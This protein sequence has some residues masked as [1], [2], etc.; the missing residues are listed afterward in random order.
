MSTDTT[1]PYPE[2]GLDSTLI[3]SL[4]HGPHIGETLKRPK[5]TESSAG[6]VFEFK[7][8]TH[9]AND[10][11]CIDQSPSKAISIHSIPD[12]VLLEIFDLCSDS[13]N[14]TRPIF[15]KNEGDPLDR[16]LFHVCKR[17]RYLI[18]AS[19]S[20]LDL[21]LFCSSG[22]PVR[23]GLG[24]LPAFPIIIDYDEVTSEDEDNVVAAL[25][26][27]DRVRRITLSGITRTLWEKLDAAMRKP[28]PALTHVYLTGPTNQ[29]ERAPVL[30][31]GL[32]GGGTL[33]LKEL[34]LHGMSYPN[35]PKFLLSAR[36]LVE[37]RFANIPPTCFVLPEDMLTGLAGL[38]RLES[39][40]IGFR[41]SIR[42]NLLTDQKLT[43]PTTPAVRLPVLDSFI[44]KGYCE[45]LED[46]LSQI[47]APRV[48]KFNIDYFSQPTYQVPQLARFLARSEIFRPPGLLSV[49]M[50]YIPWTDIWFCGPN[51]NLIFK[52]SS[53]GMVRGILHS[54]QLCQQL[55]TLFSSIV[56]LYLY[57]PAPASDQS[58]Y[59]GSLYGGSRFAGSMFGETLFGRPLL[60]L[61]GVQ[62]SIDT[63]DWIGLLRPFT[64]VTT[65]DLRGELSEN[66]INALEFVRGDMIDK[67][68][69]ALH[70][71]RFV[72]EQPPPTLSTHRF[73]S[74][75]RDAGRPVTIS[76][77]DDEEEEEGEN[78]NDDD[79]DDDGD[80][81]NDNEDSE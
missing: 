3:P 77:P 55:S 60:E 52:I 61:P 67:V 68:L 44:F 8:R 31:R 33:R 24:W 34:D 12:G 49:S 27:P 39:L 43:A 69:P 45:Y 25:E 7:S 71:L 20:R 54:V 21:K 30:P 79:D 4:H 70:T 50:R 5:N 47:D 66:I 13:E 18:F 74:T 37:L 11:C 80:S 46:L 16:Q 40:V 58:P 2:P 62:D 36:D 41:P 76:Y 22:T 73:V 65:L 17:W 14:D 56:D 26:H 6:G 81:D 57:G 10:E 9:D 38:T 23:K 42:L 53:S 51:M 15:I 48:T 35:L 72:R 28:F 32:L 78:N 59:G 19:P 64:A 1:P 29:D 63:I 75:R